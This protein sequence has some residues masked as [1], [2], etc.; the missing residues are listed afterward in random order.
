[1]GE[2]R[3]RRTEEREGMEREKVEEKETINYSKSKTKRAVINIQLSEHPSPKTCTHAVQ[4]SNNFYDQLHL[5]AFLT[6]CSV[7]IIKTKSPIKSIHKIK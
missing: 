2:E 4:I 5:F 3:E 7:L 6:P 1:M